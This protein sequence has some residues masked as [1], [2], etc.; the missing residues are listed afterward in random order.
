MAGYLDTYGVAEERRRRLIKRML[1]G[2]LLIAIVST[3]GY[4]TFRTWPQERRVKQFLTL[5][6]QK[7]FQAAY[8]LWGCTP[9]TPC[10]FYPPD[11]FTE[12]WGPDTVYA[13]AVA[14]ARVENVDFCDS[15]VVFSI[16]Y[17]NGDNVSLWVERGTNIISFSPW[18]RCPGRHWEFRQ[19]FRSLFS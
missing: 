19:F 17:P 14:S 8:T 12:D 9:E 2:G 18:V 7:D 6:Q 1:I 13:Q 11:K 4:F 5:L 10:K 16:N 3:A 15:G